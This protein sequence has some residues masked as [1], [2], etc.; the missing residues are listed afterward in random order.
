MDGQRSADGEMRAIEQFKPE[1]GF[2]DSA[3]GYQYN[4]PRLG[5]FD[6]GKFGH[7]DSVQR[8]G[9]RTLE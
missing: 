4:P 6:E 3:R 8:N 5:L 9:T 7:I 2:R 1:C